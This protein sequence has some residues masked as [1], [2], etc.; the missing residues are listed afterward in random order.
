[1]HALALLVVLH[2]AAFAQTLAHP[3]EAQANPSGLWVVLGVQDA[4]LLQELA[5]HTQGKA[6]VQG[7]ST[8]QTVV[9]SVRQILADEGLIPLVDVKVVTS[10]EHLPYA[11]ELISVLVI[12]ESGLG[13]AKV[14]ES[15][16]SRSVFF[17][18]PV[19]RGSGTSWTMTKTEMPDD[20]G[21][22]THMFHSPNNIPY[23]RDARVGPWVNGLRFMV[24]DEV[25]GGTQNNLVSRATRLAGGR[26]FV[27]GTKKATTGRDIIYK[28]LDAANGL[29][30]WER[31]VI[32][33][34]S[35][36]TR[37]VPGP[38]D[39][40]GFLIPKAQCCAWMRRPVKSSFA[41]TRVFL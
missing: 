25:S 17:D 26:M 1:M 19:V 39:V 41:M 37:R 36:R 2:V 30:L 38:D 18:R 33:L 15:E 11:D 8:D 20:V 5:E 40:V 13:G 21:E 14:P 22:W 35:N 27:L 9:D 28:A 24:G 23:S 29:P 12:N 34:N 3:K 6:L 4:Q 32:K 10:Y 16:I 31:P 7:L